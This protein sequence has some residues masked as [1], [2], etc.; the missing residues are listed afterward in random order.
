MIVSGVLEREKERGKERG[1][2]RVKG[3]GMEREKEREAVMLIQCLTNLCH[4]PML[5]NTLHITHTTEHAV[6]SM[7]SF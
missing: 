1:K 2:E 3:R 7:P 4:L 5:Q 6:R